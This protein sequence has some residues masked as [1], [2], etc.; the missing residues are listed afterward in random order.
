MGFIHALS[1]A[2][3]RSWLTA[4]KL[5]LGSYRDA[6]Y[7]AVICASDICTDVVADVHRWY[8]LT[9]GCVPARHVWHV[10]AAVC[11]AEPTWSVCVGR[12]AFG[13]LG[14]NECP[15]NFLRVQAEGACRTAAAAAGQAYKGSETDAGYPRGCYAA[16]LEGGS[17]GVF[18]NMAT[19]GTGESVSKL[20][21]S[22]AR[23]LLRGRRGQF[24][25]SQ[26]PGRPLHH[27]LSFAVSAITFMC[28]AD[29]GMPHSCS[30]ASLS[31]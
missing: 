28:R 29:G 24:G 21:C 17:L 20:L 6:Q 10:Y 15:A 30:V 18:F 14:S 12:Y 31:A 25:C 19:T 8:S 16:T 22:G 7:G 26:G 23:V 11:C 5:V 2:H 13:A 3:N 4:C 9:S 27:G 1:H